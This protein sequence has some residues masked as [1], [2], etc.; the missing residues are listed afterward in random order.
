MQGQLANGALYNAPSLRNWRDCGFRSW[1]EK[2]ANADFDSW[3]NRYTD[4]K[5]RA[6]GFPE[7]CLRQEWPDGIP[8]PAPP[9]RREKAGRSTRL[10]YCLL[11]PEIFFL[12][13]VLKAFMDRLVANDD[14]RQFSRSCWQE[15]RFITIGAPCS[16]SRP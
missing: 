2:S 1:C 8:N 6:V 9:G 16:K 7:A 3:H 5:P 15:P 12:A 4:E 13:T 10:N 14:A 11:F